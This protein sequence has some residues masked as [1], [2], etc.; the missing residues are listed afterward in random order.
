MTPLIAVDG[1]FFA[2]ASLKLL[3]G[4]WVPVLF[5]AVIVLVIITW[6]RGSSILI[7]K[8]R[9]TEVPIDTL[10]AQPGE[11]RRTS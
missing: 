5:G 11:S 2:A 1:L 7:S 10:V 8:T 6:R 4:A 9:R 3:E